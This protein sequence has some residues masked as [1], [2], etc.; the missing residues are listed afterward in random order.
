M[1][2]ECRSQEENQ[3]VSLQNRTAQLGIERETLWFFI[4]IQSV[5]LA[6]FSPLKP[7][8]SFHKYQT[9]CL[10]TKIEVEMCCDDSNSACG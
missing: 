1:G 7:V 9:T 10:E 6:G 3:S 4:E 5:V 2:R 8:F